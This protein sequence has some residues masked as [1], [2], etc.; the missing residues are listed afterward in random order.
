MCYERTGQNARSQDGLR[1]Q[2]DHGQTPGR[3]GVDAGGQGKPQRTSEMVTGTAITRLPTRLSAAGPA[4]TTSREDCYIS[5]TLWTTSQQLISS[6][7]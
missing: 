7:K 2:H 5:G 1:T 3:R 4:P 6:L